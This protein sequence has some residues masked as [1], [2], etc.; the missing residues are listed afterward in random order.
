MTEN[1]ENRARIRNY[2]RQKSVLGDF[3]VVQVTAVAILRLKITSRVQ[4]VPPVQEE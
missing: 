4:K 3:C 1:P 2:L